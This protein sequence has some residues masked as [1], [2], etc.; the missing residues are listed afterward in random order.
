MNLLNL[1]LARRLVA[2]LCL[3][4]SVGLL[5]AETSLLNASY[6]VT[7]EFYA[8]YNALFTTHWKTT[9]GESIT[10]HQSHGGSSK[11]ARA[12][13]DG[14]DADVV[15]MN[16]SYDIDMLFEKGRL[17]PKD[18]AQRLPNRSIPFN[19]TILFAVR[20]GNPKQIRDWPDL[21]KPRVTA[22]IPNPKTS[23]N[24]RYSYLAAWAQALQQPGGSPETAERFVTT[25]FTKV[26]VLDTGGRGAS[27]TFLQR[28]IGDLLLT[29]ENE[30]YALQREFG[31]N[32]FEIVT[33]SV[34]ILAEN[35]VVWV[36]RVVNKRNT[37]KAARTYL[38]YLYSE[39]GQELAAKYHFRP[40][41]REVLQ[42]HAADFPA[43]K[44]VTVDAAFGG[45][46]SAYKVHFSEGGTF[47]RIFQ[48]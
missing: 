25:L 5:R 39:P 38:E 47:D 8:E 45:W 2:A 12:V 9:T 48:R 17:I 19:S 1:P 21:I 27:I 10:L 40:S 29:F 33:P 28:G 22:V 41:N 42:R 13:I 18:W 31:T 7:R 26:P 32:A 36:D 4:G 43:L 11:Q 37:A 14:L 6:D 20:K 30:L 16:Q 24:G 35:P 15:T 44:L 23:G 34:S 3:I 46:A